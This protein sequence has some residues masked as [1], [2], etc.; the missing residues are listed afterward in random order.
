MDGSFVEFFGKFFVKVSVKVFVADD[1]DDNTT[2][3]STFPSY[4]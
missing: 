2:A 1:D 4:N 3:I